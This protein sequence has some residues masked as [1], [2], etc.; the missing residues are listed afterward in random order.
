MA[1]MPA[2]L[3][4]GALVAVCA[5]TANARTWAYNVDFNAPGAPNVNNN[6]GTFDS[7]STT[8][9][10][11]NNRLTFSVTFS[12][13][14]T[15]GFTLAMNGG[16]N[17][18]GHGG[19]MALF[20][21]DANNIGAPRLT[22]CN[23]NGQ[24]NVTS[25]EDGDGVAAGNQTP[26]LV[27]S[28]IESIAG[29]SVSADNSGGKLTLSFSIDASTVI[30][31]DPEYGIAA[32]WTGA[33]FANAFGIWMHPFRTFNAD[34]DNGNIDDL[35]TGQQGWFDGS[36]LETTLVPLPSAAAMAGVGIFGLGLRR[37]R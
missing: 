9:N 32:D 25:W 30:G 21:F 12:D 10:H 23:Y 37:R 36:Y 14:V 29:N 1:R 16:P 20:Y 22:A 26:D 34:Y 6:G 8:F 2:L 35:N 4:A 3:G 27:Q 31:H 33:K 11:S 13:Q 15:K 5:G 17:P 7:L 28:N 24:N 18:K 19:E